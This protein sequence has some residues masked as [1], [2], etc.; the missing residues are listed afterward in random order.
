LRTAVA[1]GKKKPDYRAGNTAI[2]QADFEKIFDSALAN[3]C[4]EDGTIKIAR[5]AR[6]DIA[7]NGGQESARLRLENH[8]IRVQNGFLQGFREDVRALYD[9]LKAVVLKIADEAQKLA[10]IKLP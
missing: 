8:P 7:H 10:D 2:L 9:R 6:N 5:L 1:I 4:F 3:E